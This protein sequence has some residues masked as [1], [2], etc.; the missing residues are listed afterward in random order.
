MKTTF[1]EN[2]RTF[3]LSWFLSSISYVVKHIFATELVVFYTMFLLPLFIGLLVIKVKPTKNYINA[4][5]MISFF[6]VV[7]D[8]LLA[9]SLDS[10]IVLLL[11]ILQLSCSY[12]ATMISTMLKA[13]QK[14]E[15]L[16]IPRYCFKRSAYSDAC[17]QNEDN[18]KK[19]L[20]I[21]YCMEK[22]QEFEQMLSDLEK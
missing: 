9:Q 15:N 21:I 7:C 12:M 6:Y 1:Q 18:Y 4:L 8:V 3:F 14:I 17:K 20:A 11:G 19:E 22:I 16:P 2:L 5:A 13:K 10:W